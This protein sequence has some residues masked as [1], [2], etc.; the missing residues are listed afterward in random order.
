MVC[1]LRVNAS[2]DR[3]RS[4]EKCLI[5]LV[6]FGS[7]GGGELANLLSIVVQFGGTNVPEHLPPLYLYAIG[8]RARVSVRKLDLLTI[9][10]RNA[11]QKVEAVLSS[12][13]I[14]SM[15]VLRVDIEPL[16]IVCHVELMSVPSQVLA[17]KMNSQI[18]ER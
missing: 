10:V 17:A 13:R 14:S 5:R 6:S 8:I 15:S 7:N 18:M 3:V 12:K 4:V 9:M 2:A 11:V 1:I 16:P